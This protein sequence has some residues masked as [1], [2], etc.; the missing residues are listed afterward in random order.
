MYFLRIH[1]CRWNFLAKAPAVFLAPVICLQ[2]ALGSTEPT[3]SP[4]ERPGAVAVLVLPSALVLEQQFPLRANS[5]TAAHRGWGRPDSCPTAPGSS[6]SPQPPA[7]CA[8][9]VSLPR[10]HCCL[11]LGFRCPLEPCASF[12]LAQ[13]PAARATPNTLTLFLHRAT[14]SFFPPPKLGVGP[15]TARPKRNNFPTPKAA[16]PS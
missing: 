8:C 9:A 4:A 7:A 5:L 15:N 10:A 14:L 16:P 6:V 13:A 11:F 1:P 12:P 2:G 3:V